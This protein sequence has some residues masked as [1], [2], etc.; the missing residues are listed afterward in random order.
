MP[1]RPASDHPAETTP[2]PRPHPAH[3]RPCRTPSASG[4]PLAGHQ[5]G[6]SSLLPSRRLHPC[7]DV[8]DVIVDAIGPAWLRLRLA[9]RLAAGPR[10]RTAVN[11]AAFSGET[12]ATVPPRSRATQPRTTT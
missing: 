4:E 11:Q 9:S 10:H 5:A 7:I 12:L 6:Q 8:R 1:A 3:A 2:R